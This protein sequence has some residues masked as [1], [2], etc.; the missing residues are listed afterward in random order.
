MNQSADKNAKT[1]EELKE[2]DKITKILLKRD[3]ELSEIKERREKELKELK[4]K[5]KEL[6]RTKKALLNILED[7]T[8]ARK[9][10]E[11]ERSK[12]LAVITNLVDGLLVFDSQNKLSLINPSA[13]N[14]LN[15]KA[16]EILNKKIPELKKISQLKPLLNIF[17]KGAKNPVREELSL[18]EDLILDV[19]VVP[20]ANKMLDISGVPP[21]I[22]NKM[23]DISGVPPAIM[24]K[25]APA[26]NSRFTEKFGSLIIL[27]NISREKL[28]ERMKTEF[29]SLTAHQ[30]RTPLSAIK[31]TLRL[32]LD[33]DLGEIT[34]EQ[35]DFLQRTYNSNE[36][37]I[38]L[39]N[40]LLNITRIEE[41]KTIFKLTP[42]NL[43][44]II[45]IVIDS[46]KEK[47]EMKKINFKYNKPEK[48]LPLIKLDT[49]KIEIVISNLLDNALSYT[50]AEGSIEI[51]LNEIN[52]KEKAKPSTSFSKPL[53][54]TGSLAGGPARNAR[55][56][57][58]GRAI[59]FV[60]KDS[61]IGIPKS[62]QK[63]IFTKFFRG[64]N[65][66]RM[67]TEGTGLGMFIAKNIVEA[68]NGKVWFDSQEGKGTTFH[69]TLPV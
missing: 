60:I 21:A 14:L 51:S 15:V 53:S 20:M 52:N 64:E 66:I 2:L 56:S 68:H 44:N 54:S 50:P 9:R 40:D 57:N 23:L 46:L 31:W 32:L 7:A 36:R 13:E 65:V 37:M 42:S 62:Q 48:E 28:I 67:D 4:E 41:G 69:F 34:Q 39:I 33:G 49:E 10:A 16:G 1:K 6:E 63:R 25:D 8:E 61:G 35:R 12:T 5:T 58:A 29:V 38:H 55:P 26:I 11:E 24:K 30:L 45:Q 43:E 47:L 3:F 59:E 27:H 22:A 18:K 17:E 19:A